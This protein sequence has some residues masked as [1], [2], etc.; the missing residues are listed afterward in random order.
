MKP[1]KM[2]EFEEL[3]APLIEWLN[4]NYNPHSKI[5][6]YCDSA[7]VVGGEMYIINES[8]IKD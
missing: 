4:K 7:E 8:F 5:I 6:I 2:K 1:Q 3:S